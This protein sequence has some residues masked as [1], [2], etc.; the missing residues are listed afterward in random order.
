MRLYELIDFKPKS[1]N[2]SIGTYSSRVQQATK[3]VHLGTGSFGVAYGTNS[4]KRLNQITK[5]GKAASMPGGRIIPT[6]EI[7]N[8]GYLSWLSTVGEYRKKGSNNPYFPRIDDLKIMKD[9]TGKLHYRV[10]MEKLY[11]FRYMPILDNVDLM[12]S[13]CN[14]M[15]GED[16]KNPDHE[17][18]YSQYADLIQRNL[19]EGT[20]HPSEIKDENLKQALSIIR[21]LL[22]SNN[23][24]MEDM[25]S[26][27]I[28][29]R[30]TGTIPQ[31]VIVDPIA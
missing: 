4:P 15:F 22:D 29:W 9:A 24:F 10:N 25:H 1:S 20:K 2:Q 23:D 30:I 28:M 8:D 6:D 18:G 17:V 14:K 16:V 27:N 3:P 5:I 13:L 19:R 12:S 11:D 31:L 26:G 7:K 21:S